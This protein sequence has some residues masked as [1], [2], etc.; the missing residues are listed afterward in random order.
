[1]RHL[2]ILLVCSSMLLFA[3]VA[4]AGDGKG[5]GC[6][7]GDHGC[8][9]RLLGNERCCPKCNYTCEFSVTKDKEEKKCFEVD[10]KPICIP[11]VTFPWEK[12]HC[13]HGDC[14]KGKDGGCG[15]GHGGDC[16]PARC[17]KTK[18]VK[19]LEK[20][21]YECS[22]CKCVW[23]PTSKCSGGHKESMDKVPPPP[24]EAAP[25]PPQPPPLAQAFMDRTG[26]NA[27]PDR[28]VKPASVTQSLQ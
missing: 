24:K 13:N 9:K 28:S 12:G 14:C 7:K 15:G 5:H 17:A 19:V 16:C 22:R 6:G 1:M 26:Q 2:T 4:T 25:E 3:A 8:G 23:T 21:T 27:K 11:R 20:H 18:V 10:C